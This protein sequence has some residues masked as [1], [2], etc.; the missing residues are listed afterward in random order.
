MK[1]YYSC[2]DSSLPSPQPEQHLIMRLM[3][4]TLKGKIVFYGAEEI[5][6]IKQQPFILPKLM[7]TTDLDG[8]IFFTF[9]QFCYSGKINIKL[10]LQ[11]LEIGLT[12]HFA[13]EK[14]SFN[15]KLD[16]YK[17]FQVL[18]PYCNNLFR[19]KA[20]SIVSLNSMLK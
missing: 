14:F 10:L 16:V 8:V 13:R 11:I 2:I 6:V 12:I 7:R 5:R 20:E 15:E 3:A 18:S 9:N 4:E 1:Q 17:K 19:N